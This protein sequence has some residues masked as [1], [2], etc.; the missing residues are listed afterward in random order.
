LRL[1]RAAV[2]YLVVE[3]G[4]DPSLARLRDALARVLDDPS[5]RLGL[6][7]PEPASY[8]DPDGRA[9]AATPGPG[10]SVTYVANA[11]ERSAVLVHDPALD[12]DEALLHSVGAAVR[13][14][15][16]NAWLR[17]EMTERL[18]EA[19][20]AGSRI[21]QAA[22][23]ER[24]R[25]ERDLHDGAQVRLLTAL[26]APQRVDARL[27]QSP[28]AALRD[29][30]AEADQALRQALAELRDLAR[31]IHPAVLVRDGL[32]PAVVA[33]AERSSLPVVVAVEPDRCPPA[34]EAA[35]YFTICEALANAAK[36]ARARA[37]TI[38]GRRVG[39]T[40]VVEITDDGVGGAD[41]SL[42][43][44]LR[45]LSDRLAVV[46]ATLRVVSPAGAGTRVRAE[47]PCG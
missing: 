14:M 40:L 31:G 13:L 23:S 8:V 44:G 26:M 5:V 11:G 41:V 28:D 15:L 17:S 30:V 42:G 4:P 20:A 38:T 29:T 32:A 37:V 10:R 33:P 9:L 34:V 43:G 18:A 12:E 1:R 25:L 39:G 22:D 21:V 45:G 46:G 3:L 24:R 2:G 35:A 36:H 19:R 16:D 6:W 27:R 7:Q 47:L